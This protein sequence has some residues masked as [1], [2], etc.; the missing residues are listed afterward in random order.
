MKEED[1]YALKNYLKLKI[2][3]ISCPKKRE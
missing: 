1:K 3:G 2:L